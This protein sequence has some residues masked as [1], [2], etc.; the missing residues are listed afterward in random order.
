[1][2]QFKVKS[3]EYG[4]KKYDMKNYNRIL[5]VAIDTDHED[6]DCHSDSSV[7]VLMLACKHLN[8][9]QVD[10]FKSDGIH[11]EHQRFVYYSDG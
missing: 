2:N 3:D 6:H 1:M 8:K 5:E 9:K 4:E 10:I 11:Q 7:P